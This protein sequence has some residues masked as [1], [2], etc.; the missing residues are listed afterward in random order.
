M[1]RGVG[2]IP[3]LMGTSV[4]WNITLRIFAASEHE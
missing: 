1:I 4:V 3:G 2:S